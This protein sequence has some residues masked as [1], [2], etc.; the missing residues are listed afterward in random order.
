MGEWGCVMV[1][2]FRAP[3]HFLLVTKDSVSSSNRGDIWFQVTITVIS[4]LFN[5]LCFHSYHSFSSSYTFFDPSKYS[6]FD[7][8]FTF[9]WLHHW[10]GWQ[11]FRGF[12][13][14]TPDRPEGHFHWWFLL[15]RYSL[16]FLRQ[17]ILFLREVEGFVSYW[18]RHLSPP[19][20]GA[21]F[22]YFPNQ[23]AYLLHG[24]SPLFWLQDWLGILEQGVQDVFWV[25]LKCP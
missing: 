4:Y 5:L 8:V 12:N 23:G 9:V 22:H 6:L 19:R 16:R 3:L 7:N 24:G 21:T 2:N 18:W 1:W 15:G 20:E 13:S 10:H 11:W 25:C 17:W 14:A